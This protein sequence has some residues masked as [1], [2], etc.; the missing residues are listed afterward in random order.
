[1]KEPEDYEQMDQLDPEQETKE[2]KKN[3]SSKKK[4]NILSFNIINNIFNN[5]FLH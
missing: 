2:K 4:N 5:F 3:S 1:M